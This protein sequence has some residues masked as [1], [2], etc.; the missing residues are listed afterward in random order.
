MGDSR[1]W[2]TTLLVAL[3]PLKDSRPA[4]TVRVQALRVAFLR[5]LATHFRPTL[6]PPTRWLKLKV[7]VAGSFSA[8]EK[9]VPTGGLRLERLCG[10]LMRAGFLP[11]RQVALDC[12][13]SVMFGGV[14]LD[15]AVVVVVVLVVAV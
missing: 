13:T 6:R 5:L 9:V 3:W 7:T 12:V 14:A 10:E 1:P 15:T 2:K 4:V 8:K 11:S